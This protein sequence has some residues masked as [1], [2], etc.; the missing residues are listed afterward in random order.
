MTAKRKPI[1]INMED[2]VMT[3]TTEDGITVHILDTYCRNVTEEEV[4]RIDTN[5]IRIY[6]QIM[7]RVAAEEAA[8]N[9]ET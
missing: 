6:N 1:E 3:M 4:E 2:C 9:R 7:A 8:K 5:I